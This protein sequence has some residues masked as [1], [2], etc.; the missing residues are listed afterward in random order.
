M[1][2]LRYSTSYKRG[3]GHAP[4]PPTTGASR[5]VCVLP[6][7]VDSKM[8][9]T[10]KTKSVPSRWHRE[11]NQIKKDATLPILSVPFPERPFLN[12]FESSILSISPVFA[13]DSA[14][15]QII[16]GKFLRLDWDESG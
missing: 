5:A 15:K 7:R 3:I 2:M 14:I 11:K 6:H 9:S 8:A 1:R 12:Y 13:S 10:T 4:N 16:V